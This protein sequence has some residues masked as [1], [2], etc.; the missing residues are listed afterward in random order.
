M[1]TG[2]EITEPKPRKKGRKILKIRVIQGH[3][4][5]PTATISISQQ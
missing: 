5:T 4:P 1:A 3:R 2:A